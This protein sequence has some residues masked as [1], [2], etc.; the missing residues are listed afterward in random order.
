LIPIFD[1]DG[2]D[3]VGQK[4]KNIVLLAKN[5]FMV[6]KS[7]CLTI[8]AYELFIAENKLQ[9]KINRILSLESSYL[10]KT[11]TIKQAIHGAKIPDEIVHVIEKMLISGHGSEL[12]AVR[13][14][15]NLEDM[16]SGSF[17]GMY[18]S[19]L[20]VSGKGNLLASIKQCWAS[21]W[22]EQSLVYRDKN[23]IF[24][25]AAYMA[26]LIQ[27]MVDA[28]F[29]GVAFT[30][31]PVSGDTQEI[32]VEYCQGL[33][34]ELV[35]GKV[36]ADLYRLSRVDYAVIDHKQQAN[37][38]MP[39]TKIQ[40]IARIALDV[41]Q[42]FTLPQDIEWAVDKKDCIYLL[43]SRPV[44]TKAHVSKEVLTDVWT[45][46]NVGEVLPGP[47]TPLTWDV[48][49]AT[50]FGMSQYVFE[51]PKVLKDDIAG[52]RIF[53]GRVFIS[54]KQF[55]DSFCYLPSVTP[56]I[57]A[58]VLGVHMPDAVSTYKPPRG[59]L[60]F[61][62]K[63]IFLLEVLGI[64]PR[65]FWKIKK[66]PSLSGI[67]LASLKDLID[68]NCRC[69]KLHIQ[70]TAYAIGTF[71]ML[72]SF[73]EH[74]MPKKTKEI[75]ANIL[76]G[77]EDLQTA[78]QGISLWEM[79]QFVQNHPELQSL[80]EKKHSYY[81]VTEKLSEIE[82]GREFKQYL[83]VFMHHN[84]A[85]AAGEFELKVPRW[86]DD[87]NFVL[88]VIRGF[89]NLSAEKDP[90]RAVERRQNKAK[91]TILSIGKELN[92]VQRF[93]FKGLLIAYKKFTAHR[94]NVKYE[95]MKGYAELRSYF[96]QKGKELRNENLLDAEEDIFFLKGFEVFSSD[97]DQKRICKRKNEY[98]R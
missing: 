84:G 48:F 73:L 41:E 78:A 22:S 62:A 15:S 27:E 92:I 69:F 67:D 25:E 77:R 93:I 89:L 71:G 45:R 91:E 8:E 31:N 68:W 6:P 19:Y 60:I 59:V 33:A 94:E 57:M 35:S 88:G 75:L 37:A 66:L 12:W 2:S 18:E 24:Q 98:H 17:A 54:L 56:Q 16:V 52:F 5:G 53:Q 70:S 47:V 34:D 50:L 30:V 87:G 96:L 3:S 10:E 90:S 49:R 1:V 21:L 46:A 29:A 81:A 61:W 7:Y 86:Q 72:S 26:V 83:K 20:N 80:L 4:A 9:E 40:E 11:E 44:S 58:H 23:K 95:L 82:G 85:R 76:I 63:I 74:C 97:I 32:V 39:L 51:D 65:L 42:L 79:A 28:A 38:A 14:S 13:S 55:L 64:Y 43:Q 36:S